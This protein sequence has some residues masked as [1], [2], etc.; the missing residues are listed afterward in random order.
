MAC[1]VKWLI[2]GRMVHVRYYG[3]VIADD[4]RQQSAETIALVQQ[5]QAPVHVFIDASNIDSVGV[6]LGDLR[7]LS[8]P[9]LPESG[10]MLIIAPNTL[11]RFF[12]SIGVQIT[13]GNYKFVNS[14]QEA[15]EYVTQRD[16]S[17][18]VP[19]NVLS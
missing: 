10:W 12:L 3:R 18:I 19:P 17:L 7:P 1:E 15:I 4:I 13:G 16:P 5:G 8:V 6:G 2:E 9:A 11:Y 14:V